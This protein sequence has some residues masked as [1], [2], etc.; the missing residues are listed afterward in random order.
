MLNA[1][2][3]AASS[4][5]RQGWHAQRMHSRQ[6]RRHARCVV[7]FVGIWRPRRSSSAE[8][9]TSLDISRCHPR[10]HK[11]HAICLA[12]TSL[13]SLPQR[14]RQRLPAAHLVHIA[15]LIR[16]L[17]LLELTPG[18]S[19][20]SMPRPPCGCGCRDCRRRAACRRRYAPDRTSQR[21]GC[22]DARS[23]GSDPGRR[24]RWR[25]AFIARAYIASAL[26]RLK[27]RRRAA[28]PIAWRPTASRAAR[29]RR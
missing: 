26:S 25:G 21:R 15:L 28:R 16:C 9:A 14:I 13:G 5:R 17:I 8:L 10:T 7:T 1:D 23:A 2:G 11:L 20:R 29:A 24:S 4:K 6:L 3:D 22:A 18:S 12:L 19:A 27:S